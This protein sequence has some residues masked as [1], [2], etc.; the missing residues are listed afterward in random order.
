[1]SFQC[2][3]FPKHIAI[4]MDGNGRWAH[5]RG[6]QRAAGHQAGAKTI[7]HILAAAIK[8]PIEALTLFGFSSEN[9][10]RPPSEIKHLLDLFYQTLDEFLPQVIKKNM[11]IKFI[12]ML[13]K[14]PKKLQDYFA[15]AEKVTLEN[16][17]LKIIVALNYG[18]RWDIVQAAQKILNKCL[19]NKKKVILTEKKFNQ[20]LTTSFLSD[21][22]LLI[23]TSGE[24][25]LSN[26]LLWSLAYT[27]LYFT[28]KLWPDFNEED[29]NQALEF[30]SARKR[31]FGNI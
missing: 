2:T 24:Q 26:F 9:W 10:R 3:T 23:R 15:Y 31:R 12:G 27:E 6:L 11:Q 16:K 20:Y 7:S 4:I 25:R 29:F 21:V 18:G 22:D 14:F 17:G 30:Y 8:H 13:K 5:Q 1:M 28:D 19:E